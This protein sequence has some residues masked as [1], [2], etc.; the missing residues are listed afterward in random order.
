MMSTGIPNTNEVQ[1]EQKVLLTGSAFFVSG[2]DAWDVSLLK[3]RTLDTPLQ[4]E[5]LAL[6][7]ASTFMTV[8]VAG[9]FYAVLHPLYTMPFYV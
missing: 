4:K 7:N 9:G 6:N 5:N 1:P 8:Y 3:D 2:Q